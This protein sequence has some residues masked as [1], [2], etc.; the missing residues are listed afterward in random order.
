[1]ITK[2]AANLR[3]TSRKARQAFSHSR[4]ERSRLSD[5]TAVIQGR[6]HDADAEYYD[7]EDAAFGRT[8][9][10]LRESVRE[11]KPKREVD[12]H[13]DKHG[14]VHRVTSRVGPTRPP[15]AGK[16]NHKDKAKI[17]FENTME[18]AFE[19]AMEQ[20]GFSSL[21]G[22]EPV[23]LKKGWELPTTQDLST[24]LGRN[25]FMA[26]IRRD[27]GIFFSFERKRAIRA[28]WAKGAF[29]IMHHVITPGMFRYVMWE[30]PRFVLDHIMGPIFSHL[31]HMDRMMAWKDALGLFEKRGSQQPKVRVK[32]AASTSI[33][34]HRHAPRTVAEASAAVGRLAVTAATIDAE[35]TALGAERDPSSVYVVSTAM[36]NESLAVDP[37]YPTTY[38]PPANLELGDE[39]RYAEHTDINHPYKRRVGAASS[40]SSAQEQELGYSDQSDEEIPGDKCDALTIQ[41]DG[42]DMYT[43]VEESDSSTDDDTDGEDYYDENVACPHRLGPGYSSDCA[44]D[45]PNP[46]WV[47]FG[48]QFSSDN[49]GDGP[50]KR[51]QNKKMPKQQQKKKKPKQKSQ[52]RKTQKDVFA[53]ASMPPMHLTARSTQR[54]STS[55]A[56]LS[57]TACV[58]KYA[59]AC[60]KP[61]SQAAVGACVPTFESPPSTTSRGNLEFTASVGTNGYGFALV[62]PSLANDAPC[63]IYT[64]ATFVGDTSQSL[65]ILSQTGNNSIATSLLPGLAYTTM[66]NLRYATANML[67][68]TYSASTTVAAPGV[69]G[70]LVGGGIRGQYDGTT[71]NQSGHWC[72]L[73]QPNHLNATISPLTTTGVATP[74]VVPMGLTNMS[75]QQGYESSPMTRTPCELT[76]SAKD[77][78]DTDYSNEQNE[79][80]GPSAVD[81]YP[82]CEGSSYV[83]QISGAYNFGGIYYAVPGT[84]LSQNIGSAIAVMAFTGVAGQTVRFQMVQHV[85]Y[86]GALTKD[87]AMDRSSDPEGLGRCIASVQKAWSNAYEHSGPSKM[88]LWKMF[89]NASVAIAREAVRI[90]LPRSSAMVERMFS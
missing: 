57:M 86:T 9:E 37:E 56:T 31:K 77:L 80:G 33:S 45:G 72:C 18:A 58:I 71:L 34:V 70:R 30:C 88:D 3:G 52:K 46:M 55:G 68:N 1:M 19:D 43:L 53:P 78:N 44:S 48:P 25:L 76:W 13:T 39:W 15:F 11:E 73:R 75:Q 16:K 38:V 26:D 32:V 63:V 42:D 62:M 29:S 47:N 54:R 79:A 60:M 22:V 35:I 83:S 28:G 24:A 89:V 69:L 7:E 21:P 20:G 90:A 12:R 74:N 6:L 40:S 10:S 66:S 84:T 50:P 23:M 67:E 36:V 4:S 14:G 41:F 82:F 51:I 61:F 87:M 27:I 49:A 81:M 64:T 65:A 85:E 8:K 2:S 59:I 5:R 17:E